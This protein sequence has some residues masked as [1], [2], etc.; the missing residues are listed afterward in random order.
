MVIA[1]TRIGSPD[2]GEDAIQVFNPDTGKADFLQFNAKNPE[3]RT[4]A[5]IEHFQA[6]FCSGLA[7]AD[8]ELQA[9]SVI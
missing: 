8:H 5:A 3:Q 1:T 7:T 4:I 6:G 2:S 9:A